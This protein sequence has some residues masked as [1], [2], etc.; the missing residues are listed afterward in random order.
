M[1]DNSDQVLHFHEYFKIIRNRLWVIFTIFALTVLSGLYVTNEV[2]PKVYEATAEIQIKPR[3]MDVRG[4]ARA[5][6]EGGVDMQEFQNEFE[7]MQSADV[8][9]PIITDLGLDHAWAKR[10]A[11]SSL[12]TLPRQDALGY[13]TAHLHLDYKKGTSII[14]I[15]VYSEIPRECADIANALADRY[16]TM[17]DV[18]E[19]QRVNRGA[20]SLRDQIAQQEKVVEDARAKVEQLREQLGKE[21]ISVPGG[22]GDSYIERKESELDDRNKELQSAKLDY[23]ARVVLL[24]K[25][26]NL[27]DEEFISTLDGLGREQ[28]DIAQLRSDIQHETTDITNLLKDGYDENHPRIVSMRAEIDGKQKQ[29]AELVAG[30]RRAMTVDTEMAK[31]RIELLQKEV[32][33]LDESV[34][35][36]TTLHLVPFR[37]AER[38]LEQQQSLLD[39]SPSSSSRTSP[40]PSS[41]RAPCASSPAPSRP[42]PPSSRTRNSTPPSASPP[43]SSSASASPSSSSTSTPASRPWPTRRPSSACP[44]SPSSPTRGGPMPLTQEAGRLPHAEGYRILR[45]KLDLKV[46]NGIGPSLSVLSGGPGEGKSTTIYNLA[47]V[48]AQAGQSVILVDCDLRRPTLHELLGV[49]NERGPEQL[50]A[51]RGRGGR[52]HPAQ[53]HPQAPRARRRQ[54]AHVRHRRSGRRQ[55]PPH[56]RRPQAALR[57]RAHRRPAGAWHQRRLHHRARGRLRHPRHP[58][59]PLPARNLPAGQARRRGSARQLRRHGAE[60]RC[61]PQRRL[62]LL[63]QQLRQLL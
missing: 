56:A 26:I 7:I 12:E 53:R 16:K 52:L 51:R 47:V 4:I 45:A 9:W 6:T 18:E 49:N 30:L 35:H 1:A 61:R 32:D 50:P 39:A 25:V 13:L 33:G 31:S 40:T 2:L 60:L 27:P 23:D 20:D 19:D 34:R 17:R 21:N 48:C 24:N 44:C 42:R 43:A 8:L 46:Q 3:L 41:P 22:A 55:D 5:A 29:L 11:K 62:L 28:G 54:H 15:T 10:I 59:S 58:A 57:P 36:D 14:T 37:D 63:L 38:N